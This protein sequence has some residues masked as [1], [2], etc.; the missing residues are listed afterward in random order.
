MS[1]HLRLK[2]IIALG[3]MTFALF[4]GVGNIIFPIITGFQSGEHVWIAALGFL[5]TGVGLPIIAIIALARV[6]GSI[7]A[8][9]KPIGQ[10]AGLLLSITCHLMVGPLFAIPRTS[11]IFFE[12]G[13][14]PLTGFGIIPLL[15]YTLI[16]FTLVI[17]I[18]LY[19]SRLMD[20]ISHILAPLKIIALS[21][22]CITIILKPINQFIPLFNM[23][24]ITPF[25]LGFVNG[26]LT[27]DTFSALIF[28]VIIV[29]AARFRGVKNSFL[30]TRYT[31]LSGLIAGIGLILVYLGLFKIGAD[32]RNLIAKA[33]SGIVILNAYVQNVFGN[34]GSIFLAVLI[35]IIC[36]VTAVGLTCACA[37][38]FSK[39]LSFSYKQLV[40]IFSI[41]S[42]FIS[43]L[44]L[45][46]LIQ[47]FI[48]ILTAVYP[49]CIMLIFLSFTVQWW[50]NSS[51][52][53]KIV[54]LTSFLFGIL[55]AIKESPFQYVLPMWINCLPLTKQKLAWLLPSLFMLLFLG[56]YDRLFVKLSK[57]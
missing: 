50:K 1:H 45:K 29:N 25:S 9:S 8:L 33:S 37:E 43:N 21:I 23:H 46:H 30:L 15:V 16:Y 53:I 52:I 7:T 26:Y 10:Y 57:K 56:I 42:M 14:I 38:F 49:P 13:I 41:I 39:F 20:I 18:S 12:V 44:G 24:Q 54:I 5:I 27:M 47:I 36:I 32:S 6:E 40:F 31:I 19:P 4:A 22:L 3:F 55:D 35:F 2:E 51:Y 17:S 11:N 34:L 48:P 28:S